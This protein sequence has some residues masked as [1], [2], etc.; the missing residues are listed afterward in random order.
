[1]KQVG[2]HS[3]IQNFT[4]LIELKLKRWD[5]KAFDDATMT[6]RYR[7]LVW[8]WAELYHL[9]TNI[10]KVKM[11]HLNWHI[12]MIRES[13]SE[14]SSSLFV[15]HQNRNPIMKKWKVKSYHS[16]NL[17]RKQVICNGETQ[18]IGLGKCKSF[19]K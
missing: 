10:S 17:I 9:D 1:M 7:S 12:G 5:V 4:D 15:S 3:K 19:V 13:H 2:V 11:C 6:W 8:I 18:L 14:S 16:Q